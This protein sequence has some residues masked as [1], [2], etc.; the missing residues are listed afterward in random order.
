M[1]NNTNNEKTLFNSGDMAAMVKVQESTIR[2]YCNMLEKSG[3]QFVRNDFNHR[4]FR[5][6]DVIAF[7]RLIE[8]KKHPDMTLTQACNSV[9]AW[10]KERHTD[11]EI[12]SSDLHDTL[13]NEADLRHEERYNDLLKEFQEFKEQ[14]DHFNKELLLQLKNQHEYIEKSLEKRDQS[15]MQ[16]LRETQETKN[17]IA[18][19]LESKKKWWEF[20]KR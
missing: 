5:N 17:L 4:V 15:L 9:V 13:N 14:Q 1:S 11:T 10:V 16:S 6:E 20:W 18:S 19:T 7:R 2:K 12:S 8:I 3:Y